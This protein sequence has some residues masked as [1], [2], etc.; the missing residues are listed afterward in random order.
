MMNLIILATSLPA[1]ERT[2]GG[3]H[4]RAP[5]RRRRRRR[6]GTHGAARTRSVPGET[7]AQRPRAGLW[8]ARRKISKR[9]YAAMHESLK[10]IGAPRQRLR[11]RPGRYLVLL[12]LHGRRRASS[13]RTG[14][15][16]GRRT[17]DSFRTPCGWSATQPAREIWMLCRHYRV[18]LPM[19]ELDAEV[20]RWFDEMPA[21]SQTVLRIVSPRSTTSPH[22]CAN[23][24]RRRTTWKR[25]TR[26]SSRAGSNSRANAFLEK[27]APDSSPWR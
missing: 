26:L 9:L 13:A 8:I 4:R 14:P 27:R 19:A 5:V 3:A 15:A 17:A 12:R 6:R 7:S 2:A 10:P 20:R 25:S 24:G 22:R 18:H 16:W 21:L 23:A 11:G 1:F